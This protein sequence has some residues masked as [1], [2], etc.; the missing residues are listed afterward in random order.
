MSNQHFT[1][2]LDKALTLLHKKAWA[3]PLT[4]LEQKF[5]LIPD[6]A[7]AFG[8]ELLNTLW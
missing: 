5:R 3:V 2:N 1:S 6:D 4:E 8:N 7:T